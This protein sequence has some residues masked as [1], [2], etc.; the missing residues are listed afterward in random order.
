MLRIIRK[1][2]DTIFVRMILGLIAISFVGFGGVS[3]MSGNS[4][5]IAISFKDAQ[6]VSFEEF[7]AAKSSKIDSI[8]TRYGVNITE[9][10]IKNLGVDMMVVRDF[11]T[12]AM[13]NYLGNKY[14]LD[15]TD[16][17]VMSRVKEN[18]VFHNESGEF[19]IEIFKTTLRRFRL[20][21]DQ[22]WKN[23]KDELIHGSLV[24]IF[25]NSFP[26]PKIMS[27][28]I[29][30]FMAETKIVDI[31]KIDLSSSSTD[32][33]VEEPTQEVIAQIYDANPSAFSVP[34][35]RSF[36]LLT[37]S[38]DEIDKRLNLAEED[39]QK[40]F[41]D[42][43]EDFQEDTYVKAAP[44]VKEILTSMKRED[45]ILALIKDLEDDIASGLNI[46]EISKKYNL[47]AQNIESIS[48]ES[49][50][51]EENDYYSEISDRLFEMVENE[52]S[53]PLEIKDKN[54]IVVFAINKITPSRIKNV[55]E[56][57]FLIADLW[58]K[59]QLK[60]HNLN[61][62]FQ[63]KSDYSEFLDQ[64]K[65]LQ[66]KETQFRDVKLMKQKS[67]D[68]SS[69]LQIN[70]QD[71]FSNDKFPAEFLKSIFSTNAG[72]ITRVVAKDN[73]AFLAMVRKEYIDYNKSKEIKLDRYNEYSLTIREAI[74]NEIIAYLVD[75]NETQIN[76]K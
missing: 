52:V 24:N 31:Y 6:D 33:K 68:F 15:I 2:V 9:E 46:E 50:L 72:S 67:I 56:A 64:E 40:F 11:V 41:S 25:L 42:N 71:S 17:Y 36:K 29:I 19:N 8:Q 37:F 65:N 73:E 21:E 14:D 58:K 18:P 32:F 12:K 10:Q 48:K 61:K 55:D 69:D 38:K 74:M 51:L 35:M 76:L 39:F 47:A 30:G 53:Y 5:G 43:S 44:K 1:G 59:D 3:L 66:S 62:L 49:L 27:D 75:K 22:Y 34:E 63:L 54:E 16:E 26:I 23:I 70:R 28:N 13:I 45:V 7:Q 4:K 57:R 20:Q 60:E